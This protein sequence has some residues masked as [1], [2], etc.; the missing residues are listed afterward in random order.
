ML[1][2]PRKNNTHDAPRLPRKLHVVTTWRSPDM[3]IRKKTRNTTRLKRC[4]CHAK[5]RWRSPKCCACHSKRKSSSESDAKVLR[6]SHRTTF[7]TLWNV[8]ECHEVPRLP[9]KTR[10]RNVW[11]LQKDHFCRSPQRHSHSNLIADGC[12]RL[13]TVVNG[14]ERLQTVANGCGRE[15]GVGQTRPNPQTPKVKREPFAT[16]SVKTCFIMLYSRGSKGGYFSFQ[17]KRLGSKSWGRASW[18]QSYLQIQHPEYPR[19]WLHCAFHRPYIYHILPS[20]SM[21]C[22]VVCSK[23][24]PWQVTRHGGK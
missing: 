17:E 12:E 10:L 7:D 22:K 16:R 24:S 21:Y 4:A 19:K 1:R 13:R 9:R 18:Y 15:S 23:L 3:A 20:C 2:L 11:N 8:L 14:C 6:L 5:W